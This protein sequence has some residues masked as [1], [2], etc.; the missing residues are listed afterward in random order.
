M[1]DVVRRRLRLE[2]RLPGRVA[3]GGED[4]VAV[5]ADRVVVVE[6]HHHDGT[7]A[8][9]A[10]FT[11]YRN[12]RDEPQPLGLL[13]DPI[14]GLPSVHRP[15]TSASPGYFIPPDSHGSPART[16]VPRFRS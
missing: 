4:C 10:A 12:A 15:R 9:V 13:R 8:A 5:R 14:I 16:A 3:R 6:T 2:V 1:A 7:A 11:K